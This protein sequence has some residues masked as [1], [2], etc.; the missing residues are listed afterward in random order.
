ME[1]TKIDRSI[2]AILSTISIDNLTSEQ[3]TFIF[4]SAFV[5]EKLKF[6]IK[7]D[8]IIDIKPDNYQQLLDNLI[9]IHNSTAYLKLMT[10]NATFEPAIKM[11][12]K[13]FLAY[14]EKIINEEVEI[15][16]TFT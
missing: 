5:K 9:H 2:F 1:T 12:A 11:S 10:A 16:L 3:A 13:R 4:Y 14:A 6:Q 7:N 8:I 15:L